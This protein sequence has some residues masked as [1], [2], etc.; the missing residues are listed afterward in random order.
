MYEPP[1]RRKLT[2]AER[3]AVYDKCNGHCAYCGCELAYKDMQ[4]DH[5]QPISVCG[6]DEIENML[7][8][9]RSCNYYKGA[10]DLDGFRY[11]IE[12]STMTLQRD[13]VTY[14]NAARFGQVIPNKHPVIFYFE[15][16]RE[17]NDRD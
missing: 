5:V 7:P 14:R 11:Y 15:K 13:S 17:K 8:A 12:R 16:E 10:L 9:C 3:Q 6:A 1:K 2:K 4:V